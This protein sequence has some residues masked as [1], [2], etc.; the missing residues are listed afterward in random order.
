MDDRKTLATTTPRSRI[1]EA[2]KDPER[3]ILLRGAT[4]VS[5]DPTIGDLESGDILVRGKKI[6]AIDRD[7]SSAR[8]NEN[9][10]V[11][12]ASG[13]IITPGLQD[14]HRHCWYGQLRRTL[15]DVGD[16]GEYISLFYDTLSPAFSPE[17][18]YIGTLVSALSSI[19]AGITNVHDILTNTCTALHGDASVMALREAG[20][21]ATHVQCGSLTGNDAKQWPQD[22]ARVQREFFSSSDQLLTLRLGLMGSA[23]I[24]PE[25]V[26]INRKSIEF[27]RNLGI[28]ITTDAVVA[29]SA[30][31]NIV[32]LGQAGLLGQDLLFTH[33]LELDEEAWRVMA[34][35]G[36]GVSLTTTSDSRFGILNS[37]S[38]IQKCIDLD[39]RAVGIGID[40][41]INL[42]ADLFSQMEAVVIIQRAMIFHRRYVENNPDLKGI[43]LK[44]VLEWATISGARATRDDHKVGSLTP[45]KEADLIALNVRNINNIPVNNAYGAVVSA[46]ST[47]DLE[48]VMIAGS[49]R[50]WDGALVDVDLEGLRARAEFSRDNLHVKGKMQRHPFRNPVVNRDA[51]DSQGHGAKAAPHSA[52]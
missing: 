28:A 27:A 42:R 49:V 11:L 46:C 30:S 4:I 52:A 44:K 15:P 1:S 9:I 7:L 14:T 43:S 19:D 37:I 31:D 2:N 36:V 29:K 18:I 51:R 40:T 3:Q 16:V 47:R 5:M 17:D 33:C 26:V 45:G 13:Y 23:D 25:D 24:V 22:L 39:M 50:K 38:P 12:D 21:R 34:D 6:I 10:L 8:S 41:E 35:N 48:F 32:K 20:I